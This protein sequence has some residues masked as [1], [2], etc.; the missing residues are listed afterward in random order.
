MDKR[1][2]ALVMIAVLCMHAPGFAGIVTK[3]FTFSNG[4]VADAAQVNSDFDT[5]Y[6]EFNGNI[7]GANFADNA[8]TSSKI[9][10]GSI[11][12]SHIVDGTITSADIANSTISSDDLADSSVTVPKIDLRWSGTPAAGNEGRIH[13]RTSTD[14]LFVDNG[15]SWISIESTFV[16]AARTAIINYTG[17]GASRTIT[18]MGFSPDVVTT[19][20]AQGGLSPMIRT[21]QHTNNSTGYVDGTLQTADITGFVADGFTLGTGTNSNT[22]LAACTAMGFDT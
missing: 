7:T 6:N 2:I 19:V 21:T 15:A 14:R 8:I 17:N 13:W 5:I 18:G 22:N 12:S 20:C 3:P 4:Q 16:L 10:A 11:T 9:A 1:A